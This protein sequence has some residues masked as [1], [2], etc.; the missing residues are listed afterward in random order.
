MLN[1]NQFEHKYMNKTKRKK[2]GQPLIG[3]P[4]ILLLTLT[5]Q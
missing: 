4:H 5:P 2:W 3:H 1:S